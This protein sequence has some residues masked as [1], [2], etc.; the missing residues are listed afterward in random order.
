MAAPGTLEARVLFARAGGPDPEGAWRDAPAESRAWAARAAAALGRLGAR[1]LL[2]SDSDYP[3]GLRDLPDPPPVL[4]V[5]GTLPECRRTVA[6][7]GSRAASPYGTAC[8]R[9]LGRDLGTLGLCVVSGLARGIDA[10]AHQGALEAGGSSIA[11][12]P[13]GLDAVAPRHHQALAETLCERGGL[14]SECPSGPPPARGVFVRRNRLIAALAAVTVV[15]EAAERS[16]ALSTAAAARRLGRPL[17]AVPGDIDRPTARGVHALIR[18][19]ARLCEGAGDVVAALPPTGEGGFE[20]AEMK[21]LAALEAGACAAEALAAAAGLGLDE[22]LS[23]LLRLE[24]A[25]T[26]TARPG[27]RWAR[28]RA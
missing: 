23:S 1:A 28:V 19:G 9:R 16:G 2:A 6:I 11:V 17:L 27:Q 20:T 13:G 10:A 15:V 3:S 26:V 8:A 14:A 5:R 25:G 12:L 21:L 7:V 18:T 4:F 22:T 24:W